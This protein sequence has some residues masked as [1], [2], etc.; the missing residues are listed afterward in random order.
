MRLTVD[1]QSAHGMISLQYNVAHTQDL[2]AV[3]TLPSATLG[4]TIEE[5]IKS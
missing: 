5:I 3:A 4:Y 1:S 2:L